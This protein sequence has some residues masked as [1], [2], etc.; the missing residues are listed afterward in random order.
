MAHQNSLLSQ[1]PEFYSAYGYEEQEG[2]DTENIFIK[3]LLQLLV[4][5]SILLTIYFAFNYISN[6][7]IDFKKF[8]FWGIEKQTAPPTREINTEVM[9]IENKMKA[10]EVVHIVKKVMEN[11]HKEKA[12]EVSKISI[13]P[14][15][16]PT[17][18]TSPKQ[19]KNPYL[20]QEYLDAVKKALG[21]N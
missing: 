8:N 10:T 7:N 16:K 17:K 19:V 15:I 18:V 21:K 14:L 6:M 4:V 9:P 12:L 13:V 5:L 20:S 2:S 3:V 1:N 11:I